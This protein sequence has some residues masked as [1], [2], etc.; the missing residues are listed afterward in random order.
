MPKEK[1]REEE[2]KMLFFFFDLTIVGL[3]GCWSVS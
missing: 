3:P 2:S 1:E